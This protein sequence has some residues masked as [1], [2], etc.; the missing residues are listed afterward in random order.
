MD[1]WLEIITRQFML[2]SLPVII[3]LSVAGMLEARFLPSE[4][5]P[6]KPFHN[7]AWKGTWLPFIASILLGRAVIIAPPRPVEPGIRTALIHLAAHVALCATGWLLYTWA[8]AHQPPAGLPPLHHWWAKVLMYF[9][10]C[11]ACMHL[12]PL[13]GML[14]GELLFSRQSLRRIGDWMAA[15]S[16]WLLTLIAALP[17]LDALAGQSVIFPIYEMLASQAASLSR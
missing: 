14:I 6:K 5:R 3:S 13:P 15:Y 11:M 10:L 12:L 2:Y 17:L 7:L 9:N 8:L 1:A 4:K 16:V